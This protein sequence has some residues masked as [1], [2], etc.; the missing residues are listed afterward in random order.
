MSDRLNKSASKS[1]S[2]L[3]SLLDRLTDERANVYHYSLNQLIESIR[4]DL[5][6]LLNTPKVQKKFGPEFTELHS[7]IFDFGIPDVVSISGKDSK[8]WDKL[9]QEVEQSILDFE[10]RLKN[11]ETRLKQNERK[12]N[13][14]IEFE[15]RGELVFEPSPELIFE[16]VIELADGRTLID[17]P[18]VQTISDED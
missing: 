8:A 13:S 15:I 10:P 5:E 1:I 7:S 4:R 17:F 12:L 6:F 14:K 11:V 18:R 9:L 16:S 2:A 3:P